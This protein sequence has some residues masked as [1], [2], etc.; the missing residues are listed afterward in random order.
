M[1]KNGYHDVGWSFAKNLF[2]I[3]IMHTGYHARER[4]Q[5]C[6]EYTKRRFVMERKHIRITE[7]TAM[8][9]VMWVYYVT[10]SAYA[11]IAIILYFIDLFGK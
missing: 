1:P 10:N 9:I 7:E 4:T 8:K 3:H 5:K 11:I 6:D 2:V